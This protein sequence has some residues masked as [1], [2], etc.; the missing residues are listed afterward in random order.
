LLLFNG[1][2]VLYGSNI[3][4]RDHLKLYGIKQHGSGQ[5]NIF[6]TFVILQQFIDEK[7]N[8]AG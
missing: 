2:F 7:K 8:N 1:G 4:A 5:K 3:T 6:N